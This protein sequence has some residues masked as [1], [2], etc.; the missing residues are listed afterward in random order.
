VSRLFWMRKS[1]LS[2]LVVLAA[3][4][5]AAGP[6]SLQAADEAGGDASGEHAEGDG[7]DHDGDVHD[8]DKSE[9][10][11]GEGHA[12]EAPSL[13]SF[14]LGSA[15]WNLIIFLVVFAILAK[16]VWPNVLHGLQARE[17]KIREDLEA[18]EQANAKAQALLDGYQS[19]LDEAAVQV[20]A[21]L[22]E[23]RTDAE[24]SGQRILDQAKSDAESQR[25]R[26]LSDIDTAKKVAMAD[27]AQQ[28]SNL[29]M[30]VASSVVGRELKADDH[31][32]LIRQSLEQLPSD[33]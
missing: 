13:L 1:I 28:T 30:Q 16:F 11:H 6:V 23:A 25:Q 10:G 14:D 5:F 12:E 7:H 15:I 21:M 20:Q 18:A 33:N 4:M 22:A 2:L 17:D 26:A 8:G 19:K 3:V 32:D 31:A 9:A 29:A 24:T 27:I